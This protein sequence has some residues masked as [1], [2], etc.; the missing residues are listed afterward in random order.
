VISAEQELW[1][2]SKD[3]VFARRFLQITG[4]D[5]SSAVENISPV[6]KAKAV[7]RILGYR[8]L[9]VC[10]LVATETTDIP[11]KSVLGPSSPSQLRESLLKKLVSHSCLS[12]SPHSTF[13]GSSKNVRLAFCDFFCIAPFR[14]CGISFYRPNP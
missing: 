8:I 6:D 14:I 7:A 9:D 13:A 11:P 10:Q 2:T 5:H 1:G 4:A 12:H 3:V